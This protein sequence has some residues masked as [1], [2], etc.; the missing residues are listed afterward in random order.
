VSDP[1]EGLKVGKVDGLDGTRE[2]DQGG[3]DDSGESGNR[4][5]TKGR[6]IVAFRGTYSLANTIADLRSVKQDYVPYPGDE[7]E[8]TFFTQDEDMTLAYGDGLRDYPEGLP[9][10]PIGKDVP[11]CTNCTVHSGFHSTYLSLRPLLLK[12]LTTLRYKYPSYKLHLVGH[13]LGGAIAALAGLEYGSFGWDP[14]ITTFGEPMV[15]NLEFREWLDEKFALKDGKEE[16]E[17]R[18][19]RRVTHKGDPVPL[20]PLSEWGYYPHA[21]EIFIGKEELQPDIRDLHFCDGDADPLCMA[22]DEEEPSASLLQS[23]EFGSW[24]Q[25]VGQLVLQGASEEDME[26]VEI[27]MK[28]RWG[29]LLPKRF[30]LWQLFFAHRDYFWRLGLCVPGGDPGGSGDWGRWKWGWGTEGREQE[31]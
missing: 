1:A 24:V 6:I 14:T 27:Q 5:E 12:Y 3:T 30:R 10:S 31:L 21:G 17:R 18:K 13:S 8:E 28:K 2:Q 11:Q 15:G 9:P 19:Y 22:G 25:D 7:G 4:R 20:L 23:D 26:K 16:Q 29:H